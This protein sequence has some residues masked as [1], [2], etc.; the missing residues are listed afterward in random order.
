MFCHPS[1]TSS[2]V[3]AAVKR[4]YRIADTQPTCRTLFKGEFRDDWTLPCAHYELA[5]LAWKKSCDPRC[6][7]G[8]EEDIEAYRRKKV[9][10]C[11]EYLEHVKTWESFVLDARVGMKVQTG[12]DSIAWLK[13]KKGWD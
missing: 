13:R 8:N 2:C 7:A 1:I 6:W 4:P 10:E 3:C 5:V 9:E 12:F 11:E